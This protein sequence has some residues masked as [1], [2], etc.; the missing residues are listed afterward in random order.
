MWNRTSGVGFEG[1]LVMFAGQT[2]A[3]EEAVMEWA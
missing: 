3:E 2:A 1:V